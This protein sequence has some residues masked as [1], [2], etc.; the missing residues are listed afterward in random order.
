M[1]ARQP[2]LPSGQAAFGDGARLVCFTDGM[3]EARNPAD[4]EFGEDRL[5]ALAL[6][7]PAGSAEQLAATLTD[8]VTAWT[9]GAAQDD[10][11]LIVI[12]RV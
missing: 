1:V 5:A 6:G 8:A 4:E 9:G 12:E 10:A 7:V 11:T 3:T 2:A